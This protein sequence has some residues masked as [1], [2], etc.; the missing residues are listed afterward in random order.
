MLF[1]EKTCIWKRTCCGQYSYPA[2]F[3]D[4][5]NFLRNWMGFGRVKTSDGAFADAFIVD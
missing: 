2:E 3:T 4:R 1:K 5:I